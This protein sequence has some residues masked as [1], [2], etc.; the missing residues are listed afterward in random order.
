MRATMLKLMW[1]IADRIVRNEAMAQQCAQEA[2]RRES[3]AEPH[4]AHL[5][6]EIARDH[7]VTAL[8]LQARLTAARAEYVSRFRE[9]PQP[10]P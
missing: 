6:R 10:R 5:L 4:A 9:E 2:Y 1:D 8:K 3:Q 7:R